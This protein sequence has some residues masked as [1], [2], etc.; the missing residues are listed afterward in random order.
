MLRFSSIKPLTFVLASMLLVLLIAVACG[1][2]AKATPQPTTTPAPAGVTAADVAAAVQAA[3]AGIKPAEGV[4]AEEIGAMVES[5]VVAQAQAG[6]SAEEIRAMVTAAVEAVAAEPGVTQADLS[7]AIEAVAAQAQAGASAEEIQAMVKAAV[8]A[9]SAALSEDLAMAVKDAVSSA[10]AAIPTATPQPMAT[11]I[12]AAPKLGGKLTVALNSFLTENIA[13]HL[14]GKETGMALQTHFADFLIGVDV[15]N[16]LSNAWGWADSWEMV[17]AA[18]WDITLKKGIAFHDGAIVDAEDLVKNLDLLATEESAASRCLYCGTLLPMYDRTEILEPLKV[19]IHLNKPYVFMFN[20]LPPIG[21]ADLYMFSVDAWERGGSTPEGYERV[22]AIGTG[23]WNF[24]ERSIGTSVQMDRFDDHYSEDFRARFK[25]IEFLNVAEDAPRLALVNTGRV[26]IA[27]MSGPYVDEIR[28]AGLVVDG[29]K[30]IDNVY[31]TF[32]QSYDPGHCTNNRTVRLALNLAVDADAIAANLWA[33]GTF[34]R[35][36]HPYTSPYVEGWDPDQKPYGYDPEEAKRLLAQEGC[37]D[38]K[39]DAYSYKGPATPEWP[40]LVS[41]IV[42]YFQGV[43]IDAKHIPSDWAGFGGNI[44]NETFGPDNANNP[45]GP[46]WQPSARNLGEMIRVHGLC[47]S[48]GGTLCGLPEQDKY[49]DL[50]D[51]YNLEEDSVKRQ[52][53]AAK[54]NADLYD[55]IPGIPIASRD[56]I[57]ALNPETLCGDWQPI[58]GTAVH[59]MLNTLEPC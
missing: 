5:V 53:L 1:E 16:T 11:P 18:K 54:I 35:I 42:T 47:V 4:S 17:D 23:P 46:F 37:G 56:G 34:S 24:R 52:A 32:F 7:A 45:M 14:S 43:G 26:D 58:D 33:P 30:S 12:P 28:K 29:P 15:D 36:S 39:V 57:W 21:G 25:E 3:V 27:N 44:S 9:A 49:K 22:G 59:L 13:P 31:Y 10:V 48:R 19:R 50:K 20:L 8:E 40:D 6:A 2:D 55:L 51:Q 38:M 41:S